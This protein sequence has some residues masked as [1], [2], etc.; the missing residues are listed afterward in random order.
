MIKTLNGAII[1]NGYHTV[2][3][4]DKNELVIIVFIWNTGL[5]AQLQLCMLKMC[6]FKNCYFYCVSFYGSVLESRG[7]MRYPSSEVC[8]QLTSEVPT[9]LTE[10]H[11]VYSSKVISSCGTLWRVLFR[12]HSMNNFRMSFRTSKISLSLLV[13]KLYPGFQKRQ[14]QLTYFVL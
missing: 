11:Y 6:T 10:V 2:R 12:P 14:P 8:T 4:F 13:I 3:Y 5:F 9:D 7:M 1:I